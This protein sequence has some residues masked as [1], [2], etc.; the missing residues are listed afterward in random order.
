M[1]FLRACGDKADHGD[2]A[3]GERERFHGDH[4]GSERPS[5]VYLCRNL[6]GV[7]LLKPNVRH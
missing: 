7:E 4:A 3:G 2:E 1:D 6:M 5:V